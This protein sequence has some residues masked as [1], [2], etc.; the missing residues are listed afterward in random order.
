MIVSRLY[1][2]TGR[3]FERAELAARKSNHWKSE[4][5]YGGVVDV[6]VCWR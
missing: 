6:A 4:T 1:K 2:T 5:G 3:N